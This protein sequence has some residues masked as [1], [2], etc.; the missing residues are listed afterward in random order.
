MFNNF[1]EMIEVTQTTESGIQI[2]KPKLIIPKS[3]FNVNTTKMI[4][5]A[6]YEDLMEAISSVQANNSAVK[7]YTSYGRK[8]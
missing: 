6:T 8:V 5:S 4:V 7:D 2:A 1:V 3:I